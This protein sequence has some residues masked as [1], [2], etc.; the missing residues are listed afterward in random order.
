MAGNSYGATPSAG[1]APPHIFLQTFSPAMPSVSGI[2]LQV[3]RVTSQAMFTLHWKPQAFS[4][5]SLSTAVRSHCTPPC[6]KDD[7]WMGDTITQLNIDLVVR[8]KTERKWSIFD[9]KG[10]KKGIETDSKRLIGSSYSLLVQG[11]A[12]FGI[13]LAMTQIQPCIKKCRNSDLGI[14]NVFNYCY[15]TILLLITVFL[16]NRILQTFWNCTCSTLLDERTLKP[17]AVCTG[18]M[19]IQSILKSDSRLKGS[20]TDTWST[21][22]N[23]IHI[24][25]VN[26]NIF[27]P[28]YRN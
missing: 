26:I 2:S 28:I 20:E 7:N 4:S 21:Q 16:L 3:A 25:F 13:R 1:S 18:R 10:Y 9:S 6:I 11:L 27:D 22:H 19:S 8:E 24:D 23:M 17:T 12:G 15:T 14:S 5:F